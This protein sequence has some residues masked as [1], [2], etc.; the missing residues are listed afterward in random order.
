MHIVFTS[1]CKLSE[2]LF[3]RGG[4]WVSSVFTILSFSWILFDFIFFLIIFF[5]FGFSSSI[6]CSALFIFKLSIFSLFSLFF[7]WFIISLLF[8][9]SS[10]VI[11]FS[12][13]S[14]IISSL[15]VSIIFLISI[16]IF[17]FSSSESF[18]EV[19][20][21]SFEEI[22]LFFKASFLFISIFSVSFFFSFNFCISLISFLISSSTNNR[23]IFFK[24]IFF[25]VSKR[26]SSK[27][28]ENKLILILWNSLL[29]FTYNK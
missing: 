17:F 10:L 13:F 28:T 29:F 12:L 21:S 5:F 25:K 7:S 24:L 14:T 11:L 9:I 16:L 23:C 22:L 1:V 8:S 20:F 6:F 27:E 26:L 15:F 18:A 2:I 4:D 3:F 19:V